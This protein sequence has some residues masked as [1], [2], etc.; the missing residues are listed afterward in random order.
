M[1][2]GQHKV[3]LHSHVPPGMTRLP[4]A[5]SAKQI[6][7]SF[8]A[9]RPC[10]LH[11]SHMPVSAAPACERPLTC[12]YSCTSCSSISRSTSR[13]SFSSRLARLHVCATVT[14]CAAS[15]RSYRAAVQQCALRY[16]WLQSVWKLRLSRGRDGRTTA[17][18]GPAISLS[19]R[20]CCHSSHTRP[21]WLSTPMPAQCPLW[22]DTS[23]AQRGQSR[24]RGYL[25][26]ASRSS[27]FLM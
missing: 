3:D 21:S 24:G 16:I 18:S 10:H 1:A 15:S 22:A 13:S 7:H 23:T 2:S 14:C 4:Y 9:N 20:A 12:W 27:A 26:M 17:R 8:P 5:R 25:R 6:W 11:V 19:A